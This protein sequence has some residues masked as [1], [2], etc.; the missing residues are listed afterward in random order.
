MVSAP[1]PD[2]MGPGV[3]PLFYH[4]DSAWPDT[5]SIPS[6]SPVPCGGGAGPRARR[7]RR[8]RDR[9]AG[10]ELVLLDVN[11]WPSFALYREEAAERIAAHVA[12]RFAG[13]TR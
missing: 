10:G 3:V 11:A 4:K 2:P 9:D 7:L 6:C 1:A 13:A 12:L 5:R 8:R